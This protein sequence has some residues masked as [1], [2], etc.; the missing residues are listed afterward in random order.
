[1]TKQI[2]L[3]AAGAA[4][5]LAS[6]AL[7]S[8]GHAQQTVSKPLTPEQQQ[9]KDA[10]AVQRAATS[11]SGG[12]SVFKYAPGFRWIE[13]VDGKQVRSYREDSRNFTYTAIYLIEESTSNRVK[14]D[15]YAK[16]INYNPSGKFFVPIASTGSEVDASNVTYVGFSTGSLRLRPNKTWIETGKGAGAKSFAFFEEARDCCNVYMVDPTRSMRLEVNMVSKTIYYS[17]P[18]M[19]K[20]QPLYA[21]DT[22]LAVQ[23]FSRAIID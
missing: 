19:P 12:D 3:A 8:P 6:L 21:I 22:A 7:G 20:P 17:V 10:L 16:R 11:V 13:L 1:M 23:F 2:A 15:F 14:L 4:L 5:A 9:V 18:G